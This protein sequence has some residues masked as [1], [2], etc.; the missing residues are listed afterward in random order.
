MGKKIMVFSL[1]FILLITCLHAGGWN[2]TLMGIRALAIGAAFAGLADDPSAIFY[3]PAG[4]SFQEE[5]F[6]LSINGIYISPLHEYTL[7]TG[8]SAESKNK[9]SLPQVFL[10]YKMN[11][12]VTLGFGAYA[13]YAGGGVDWKKD[14]LGF[15]FKTYL[16]VMSLTPSISYQISEKFAIGFNLNFYYGK[17]EVNTDMPGFGPMDSDETGNNISA[18]LGML[19]KPSDKLSM[20]LSIRGPAKMTL[21]GT[22]ALTTE[23]PGFGN[24]R[25]DLDSETNFQLPWDFEFGISYRLR[26]NLI[27]SGSAQYTMWSALDRVEKIIR[28]VPMVGDQYEYENLNFNNIL[29]MRVGFEYQIPHGLF[30]RGGIGVDRAATPVDTLSITNIDVDKLTLLGGFGYRTG[31][32]QIDFVAISAQGREREKTTTQFGFPFTERYN[33]SAT[34]LGMGVTFIF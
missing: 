19:Y 32:M 26:E 23:A 25:F 18:G 24:I 12:K 6:N 21:T 1:S 2:N 11:D 20:G 27:L 15:P 8:I 4:I 16:G 34:I 30:I 28:N 29:I 10:T 17:L 7:P 33:L 13:P 31:S 14:E 5:K 22:T 3:N 9:S